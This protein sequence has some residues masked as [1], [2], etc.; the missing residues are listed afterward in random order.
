MAKNDEQ[1]RVEA[2]RQSALFNEHELH[3]IAILFEA[4]RAASDGNREKRDRLMR[5]AVQDYQAAKNLH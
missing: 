5:Q 1:K 4:V 2:L 3:V